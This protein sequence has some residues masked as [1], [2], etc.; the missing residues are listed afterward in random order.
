MSRINTDITLNHSPSQ[1]MTNAIKVRQQRG[2]QLVQGFNS[3]SCSWTMTLSL[4][5][6]MFMLSSPRYHFL[7]FSH[8]VTARPRSHRAAGWIC[9]RSSS[10]TWASLR[11]NGW[12]FSVP[13][14]GPGGEQSTAAPA[15]A[16]GHTASSAGPAWAPEVSRQ[17]SDLS[18]RP[19]LERKSVERDEM[20]VF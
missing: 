17:P 13:S 1:Y 8:G 9:G 7:P 20:L 18:R 14:G 15:D 10:R 12:V 3:T 11:G 6:E 5:V 16:A 4:Q 2:K 19:D